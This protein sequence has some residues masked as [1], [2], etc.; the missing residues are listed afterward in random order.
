M[1]VLVFPAVEICNQEHETVKKFFPAVGTSAYNR[2]T[3]CRSF[4]KSLIGGW[5]T[6][7]KIIMLCCPISPLQ[8]HIPKIPEIP[9]CTTI[10]KKITI[11]GR[12]IQPVVA[13]TQ[14]IR[15][16]QEFFCR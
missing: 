6:E 9:E 4:Y 11:G 7:Y 15:V 12:L 8:C 13:R 1:I 16:I 2:I 14:R 10:S 3:I 5:I